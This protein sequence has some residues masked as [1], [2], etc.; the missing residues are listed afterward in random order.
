MPLERQ[1][2]LEDLIWLSSCKPCAGKGQCPFV[3]R[4]CA[5]ADALDIPFY[6]T[7]LGNSRLIPGCES[8]G[9]LLHRDRDFKAG[10]P[11]VQAHVNFDSVYHRVIGH[12]LVGIRTTSPP[13]EWVLR[14]H[15]EPR[16]RVAGEKQPRLLSPRAAWR[17]QRSRHLPE[18]H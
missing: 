5:K 16:L 8:G 15:K 2:Q 18:L 6:R 4:P 11:V 13:Q 9:Y 10:V 14:R 12:F 17:R 7:L 1:L 3:G